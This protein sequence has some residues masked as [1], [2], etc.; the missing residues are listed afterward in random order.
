[1]VKSEL[2]VKY[3]FVGLIALV[4]L[5]VVTRIFK[6]IGKFFSAINPFNIIGNGISTITETEEDKA[7]KQSTEDVLRRKAA[8]SDVLRNLSK[9]DCKLIADNIKYALIGSMFVED[10]ELLLSEIKKIQNQADFDC[11]NSAYGC[12]KN[13]CWEQP[14]TMIQ[15][16]RDLIHGSELQ[17]IEDWFNKHNISY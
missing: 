7:K 17:E 3:G 8:E 12:V 6:G 13:H 14:Q 5:F 11:V 1:M 16:I 4:V 2:I 15:H 9:D 10:E